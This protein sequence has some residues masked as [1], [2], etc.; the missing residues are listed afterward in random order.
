MGRVQFV[1]RRNSIH[2]F[3]HSRSWILDHAFGSNVILGRNFRY[4]RRTVKGTY[5]TTQTSI[6]KS[7]C[8]QSTN[9]Q[10]I[11]EEMDSQI[12]IEDQNEN[13]GATHHKICGDHRQQVI[14]SCGLY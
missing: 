13:A 8:G 5:A 7:N 14:D 2:R 10:K 3:L 12:N 6:S 11:H 1:D 9:R 4:I